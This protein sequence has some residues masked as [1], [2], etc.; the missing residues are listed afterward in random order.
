MSGS[1]LGGVQDVVR[2]LLA[3]QGQEFGPACWAVAQ[4]CDQPPTRA[5]LQQLCDDGAILR[6]HALRPTWHLV[7]P[8]D[9][10]WLLDLT[11][12]RVLTSMASVYRKAGLDAATLD[13]ATDLIVA[14]ISERGGALAK[15][16]LDAALL[17]RR[18]RAGWLPPTFFLLFAELTGVICSGRGSGN[19]TAT[20]CSPTGRRRPAGCRGTPRSPNWSCAT[21]PRTARPPSTT[22][23]GGRR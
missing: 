9:I 7:L 23:G 11:G 18:C 10:G 13:R 17:H 20:R 6:T 2:H 21:S 3:V 14:A 8:E 22:C 5:E 15:R 19:S 16:D 12:P 1:R 4:R